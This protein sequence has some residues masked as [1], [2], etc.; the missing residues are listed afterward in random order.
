MN[1]AP[2]TSPHDAIELLNILRLHPARFTRVYIVPV[3][4]SSTVVV[5]LYPLTGW[6][7]VAYGVPAKER[8]PVIVTGSSQRS[9]LLLYFFGLELDN[10]P[11][12]L[13]FSSL[14]VDGTP[15]SDTITIEARRTPSSRELGHALHAPAAVF[16]LL[17]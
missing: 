11:R 10:I 3:T 17:P 6:D 15:A 12:V 8:A 14:A 2:N 5:V 16:V 4:R 7:G 13:P 9:L 1:C